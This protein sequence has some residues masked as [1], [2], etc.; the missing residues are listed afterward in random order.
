[1]QGSL[2]AGGLRL[3]REG[4]EPSGTRW[5]VSD[6]IIL[7]PRASPVASWMVLDGA[8]KAPS[9]IRFLSAWSAM[10]AARFS[11][12]S[13]ACGCIAQAGTRV[14]GGRQDR[15]R[16]ST[17]RPT[18][19]TSTPTK[20][21]TAIS[22]RRSPPGRSPAARRSSS[23]RHRPH[24]PPLQHHSAFAPFSAIPVPLRSLIQ[25]YPSRLNNSFARASAVAAWSCETVIRCC[26]C[27]EIA[28]GPALGSQRPLDFAEPLLD[29]ASAR[30]SCGQ[31]SS[32]SLTR[33]L[34]SMARPE[35]RTATSRRTP[36]V[37]R[38]GL[39]QLDS[40]AIPSTPCLL[41]RLLAILGAADGWA[42]E[43]P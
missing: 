22:S 11:L 42:A 20:V 12:S 30:L 1:M 3:C 10:P 13:T 7:L 43:A 38:A 15:S 29:H 27:G 5:K 41:P 21:S 23:E 4:V 40:G 26:K 19:R 37:I 32:R 39:G 33:L 2:P 34:R 35:P 28:R 36:S 14:A 9:L 6:Y 25:E 16:F 24:A 8:I 31:S 18:A 17:S